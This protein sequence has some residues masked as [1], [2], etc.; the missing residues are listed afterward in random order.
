[1]AF[2]V[3]TPI[4]ISVCQDDIIFFNR[5]ITNL[6][7]HYIPQLGVFQCPDDD[8]YF[9]MW[10]LQAPSGRVAASLVMEGETRKYGPLTTE[11]PDSPSGTASMSSVVRCRA[12]DFVWVKAES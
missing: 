5:T 10:S 12:G 6:G 11:V 7:N 8:L 1:M 2:S 3:E 4:D 9:A